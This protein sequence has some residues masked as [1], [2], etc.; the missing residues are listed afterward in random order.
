M[1]VSVRGWFCGPSCRCFCHALLSFDGFLPVRFVLN[2]TKAIYLFL[3][4]LMLVGAAQAAEEPQFLVDADQR[5][6]GTVI[7]DRPVLVG[8][9]AQLE[10]APGTLVKIKTKRAGIR[11]EGQLLARGSAELP[12][13][14]EVPDGWRGIELQQ[15]SRVSRF[16]FVRVTGAEVAI[17]A[18]LSQFEVLQSDFRNCTTAIKLDRQAQV[19]I[20][21]SEFS[22][23]QV[24]VDIGTRSQGTLQENRFADN[25]S[26][27]VASHNS[28]GILTD[29]RFVANQQAVYLQHLFPGSLTGNSFEGNEIAVVCD[30][31]MASPVIGKNRFVGNAKGI[32]SLLASKPQVQNNLFRDNEIALFNNQLGSPLVK[33][34][35]F[36][37]NRLAIMNERRS[38]PQITHNQFERNDLALLCDY[39]S[40]P[41]VKQNNF[42]GNTLAVKLGDH[43]SADMEQQGKSDSQMRKF[44]AESGR[45]GKGA[46]FEPAS[47]VVDVSLNWWGGD[48]TTVAEPIFFDRTQEKWVVDEAS[49]E[50]FL[51]DVI[52][53]IPWLEQPVVDAGINFNK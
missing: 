22:G 26:A 42:V 31:T 47:G 16:E 39:L 9:A 33:A 3:V 18:S 27:V 51:R 50:R 11:V 32:V 36:A 53:F 29:N 2:G 13:R 41:V 19:E 48:G 6:Q 30:Q 45:Q 49:G 15:A 1:Y 10:I 7:L 24:A 25:A 14:F 35:L 43:Q 44:I 12:I 28:S 17:A 37:E 20:L 34:N 4:L 46:V 21:Q 40:Y 52:S 8:A 23:N 5:W 38:A